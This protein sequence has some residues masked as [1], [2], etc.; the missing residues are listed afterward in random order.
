MKQTVFFST[1]IA[2]IAFA[3]SPAPAQLLGGSVGGGL[4]GVVSGTLGN[5]GDPIGRA[6]GTIRSTVDSTARLRV[7]RSDG[8]VGAVVQR[9]PGCIRCGGRLRRR[10]E[11]FG[12]LLGAGAV[13][14]LLELVVFHRL[15]GQDELEAV[16]LGFAQVAQ[17]APPRV[18]LRHADAAKGASRVRSRL[19]AI[20]V[21]LH[22]V[23]G[24]AMARGI[25]KADLKLNDACPEIDV[26]PE[27][28]EVRANGELLTC[29]PASELPMAQRYFLY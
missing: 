3:A 4:G 6:R 5:A 16:G 25:G 19:V 10:L 13:V 20:S 27:T 9:L 14:G 21:L 23:R 12:H 26:N 8:R 22:E 17:E 28:Y 24:Q 15:H 18:K 11:L 29:E 2:A 1:A 7:D